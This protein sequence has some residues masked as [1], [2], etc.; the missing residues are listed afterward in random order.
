MAVIPSAGGGV[1]SR[2]G[3]GATG[4]TGGGYECV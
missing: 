4:A 3:A 1:G 2:G